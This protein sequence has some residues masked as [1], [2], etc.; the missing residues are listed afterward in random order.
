MNFI[1]QK[2][3]AFKKGLLQ[4]ALN[5]EAKAAGLN[6]NHITLTCG[7]V[8]YFEKAGQGRTLI[9]L[10][11]AGAD[12]NSW[13]RFA[14]HLSKDDRVIIPDLPGHGDS[15]LNLSLRY[16]IAQ[17]ALYL[18]ELLTRLNAG[19]IHIV[20]HSMGAAVALRYAHLHLKDVQSLILLDAAGVEK[21]PSEMRQE[22]EQTGVHPMMA[23]ESTADYKKLIQY[24]MNKPPYIPNFFLELLATDKINRREIERKVFNDIILDMDQISILPTL[25]LPVLI[26]WGRLD[27]VLH[28][29]DAELLHE[30]LP[31]SQKI[32]LD[33][34]GHVPMIE[35]PQLSAKLCLKF[36][37]GERCAN[38]C[39]A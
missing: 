34:I 16:T 13:C 5:A 6:R 32:I 1:K 21:T 29:N 9:L 4:K 11:G 27:R 33:D 35:A 14:K 12:K 24:G 36:M 3:N 17:Q 2:W 31:N 25:T 26:I 22:L 8:S 30:L 39:T 19:S 23:I 7:E 15:V 28:V 38:D 10:H 18:H 37:S 20:G